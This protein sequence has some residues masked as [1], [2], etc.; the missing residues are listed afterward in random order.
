MKKPFSQGHENY[1]TTPQ[2]RGFTLIEVVVVIAI[3]GI[4]S[5]IAIPNYLGWIPKYRLKAAA[6][7]ICS[8]MQKTKIRAVKENHDWAVVINETENSYTVYSS[9][10]S[11]PG[12]NDGDETIAF[13]VEL[14]SIPGNMLFEGPANETSASLIVF[15]AA[16]VCSVAGNIYLSDRNNT[17]Y[18]R[19]QTTSPGAITLKK[20]TGT[21]WN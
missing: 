21:T 2:Q 3:I 12:W 18:Y 14:N 7:D 15:T 13:K 4:I 1:S 5:A 8:N 9:E 19:I 6:R 16:G 11:T 20:W 10:G 17:A